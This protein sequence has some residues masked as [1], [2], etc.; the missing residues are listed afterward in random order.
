[1]DD[2]GFEKIKSEFPASWVRLSPK[3]KSVEVS[4]ERDYLDVKLP[5]L[6]MNRDAYFAAYHRYVKK[7]A[8]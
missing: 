5:E 6:V 8:G 3:A 1:M 4:P 2:V 7:E